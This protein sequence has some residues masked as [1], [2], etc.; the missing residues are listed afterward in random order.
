MLDLVGAVG[1][2]LVVHT[3]Y[4]QSKR[5]GTVDT[6]AAVAAACAA[7]GVAVI[8]LSSDVVFDG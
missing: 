6:A 5:A 2:D 1:P 3:A 8:H 7:H 4:S